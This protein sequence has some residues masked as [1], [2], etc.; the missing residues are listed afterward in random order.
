MDLGGDDDVFKD[1]LSRRA[2]WTLNIGPEECSKVFAMVLSLEKKMKE[3]ILKKADAEI[4]SQVQKE[5]YAARKMQPAATSGSVEEEK[6]AV[7]I[8]SALQDLVPLELVYEIRAPAKGREQQLLD[9][10]LGAA[11]KFI[12]IET[13][14]IDGMNVPHIA[15]SVDVCKSDGCFTESQDLTVWALLVTYKLTQP[16]YHFTFNMKEGAS[17]LWEFLELLADGK[18][19]QKYTPKSKRLVTASISSN[20]GVVT[21]AD[22]PALAGPRPRT[23]V[24][25]FKRF[26]YAHMQFQGVG[27]DPTEQMIYEY[28]NVWN[29]VCAPEFIAMIVPTIKRIGKPFPQGK[30]YEWKQKLEVPGPKQRPLNFVCNEVVGIDTIWAVNILMTPSRVFFPRQMPEFG[31]GSYTRFIALCRFD[32]FVPTYGMLVYTFGTK[33]L[34]FIDTINSKMQPKHLKEVQDWFNAAYGST[35]GRDPKEPLPTIEITFFSDSAQSW[36][37]L[38]K[39]LGSD[40]SDVITCVERAMSEQDKCTITEYREQMELGFGQVAKAGFDWVTAERGG[41]AQTIVQG[42]LSYGAWR[43]IK[44]AVP[45]ALSFAF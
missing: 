3:S 21:F 31:A 37:T 18:S 26:M 44:A 43:A 1:S 20:G 36:E 45:Y 16:D 5:L 29:T 6:D 38:C 30:T 25:P 4:I 33:K 10:M 14:V 12:K 28:T 15:H 2:R 39:I 17:T 8:D 40:A 7:T 42:A 41:I 13:K 34:I 35:L 23:E 27:N 22:A 9:E 19:A 11:H 24:S 32:S